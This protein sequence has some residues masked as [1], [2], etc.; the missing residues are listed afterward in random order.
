METPKFREFIS[1]AKE[2]SYR[3]V[4]L[5]HD[6]EDDSNVSGELVKKVATRLGIKTL[7]AEFRG[8]YTHYEAGQQFVNTFPVKEGKT[9]YPSAQSMGQGKV[10]IYEKPFPISPENTILMVRGVGRPGLSGN[11][12]WNDKC[13]KWEH[14]GYT[15]INNMLC[16]DL[17]SDKV[18]TQIIFDREDLNTPKTSLVAHSED[19]ERALKELDSEFPIILK[20]GTGTNGIGVILV[21]S[22]KSLQSIIQLL[23]RENEY[24]DIILQEQIKTDYDVRVIV[25]QDEIIGVMKRPIVKGDFRSN[26]SQGSKPL[27]HKLTEL[28][29]SESLRAAKAVDGVLVGVDF[30][31]AKNREKDSPYFLE[32]NNVPGLNGIEEAL[33]SEG[34]V[35]EK[36]LKKLHDRG[37]WANA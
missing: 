3:L 22:A 34:S 28:E 30:I 18:M 29:K 36:I 19:T 20:T 1:E 25:L 23:Y 27:T 32:V 15:L 14:E 33:K 37:L 31:P 12:A 21:E 6:S 26:V 35:V 13:K 9:E 24:I 7:L 4:I 5:S 17:C 8:L 16:H 10:D 2:E 11:H